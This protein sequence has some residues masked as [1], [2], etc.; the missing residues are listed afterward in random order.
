MLDS[1]QVPEKV[2][3]WFVGL[4]QGA[5]ETCTVEQDRL[6][7]IQW[8][9]AVRATLDASTGS[10]LD[11]AREVYAMMNTRRTIGVVFNGL[12]EALRNYRDADLPLG[13]KIALPVTLGAMGVIGGQGAGIAALG[14]AIGVPALLMVF[15]GTAGI[16]S[17]IETFLGQSEARNY[18]TLVLTMI[19]RDE[20]LRRASKQL[21]DAM[22]NQPVSPQMQ[23]LPDD[24]DPLRES[25]LT[26]DPFDFE[27]HVMAHFE[28]AGCMAWVTRRSNDLGVDGFARHQK[29]LIVVQCKRYG[30]AQPVGRPT[31]QQLKGV[32]EENQ[33]DVGY[34]VT[35]GRFTENCRESALLGK[36]IVLVDLDELIR[37]EKHGLTLNDQSQPN[38]SE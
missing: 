36:N 5:I 35:T 19:A 11:K 20:V 14:G 32:V 37:W 9:S 7:V 3:G 10:T 18:V 30:A 1:Y 2:R 23:A 29:A 33:A 8:L 25:L 17:I 15:I 4:I 38:A 21:R 13:V 16:T 31:V 12:G 24:D 6:E 34:L 26:M 22:A 27:R 28:R